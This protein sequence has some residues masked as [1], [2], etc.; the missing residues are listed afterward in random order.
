MCVCG[1]SACICICIC[2]C[3]RACTLGG[4]G[5]MPGVYMC[6]GK[7]GGAGVGHPSHPKGQ[8]CC[9][10]PPQPLQ[11]LSPSSSAHSLVVRV[12][13]LVELVAQNLQALAVADGHQRPRGDALLDPCK[14]RQA[15]L[16]L[17]GGGG[18][19]ASGRPLPG[20]HMGHCQEDRDRQA[21]G[22]CH[23]RA[24]VSIKDVVSKFDRIWI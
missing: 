22:S 20:P 14:G 7:G 15:S 12:V 6:F 18:K 17:W 19:E 2:A 5:A 23:G 13:L 3:M 8:R 9:G 10:T 4:T 21:C 11:P 1:A 16:G 24:G